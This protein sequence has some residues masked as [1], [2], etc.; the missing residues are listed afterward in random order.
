MNH[1]AWVIWTALQVT[2]P[3]GLLLRHGHG[4][5]MPG[6]VGHGVLEVVQ[7]QGGH[8]L[9]DAQPDQNA[10]YGDVDV[11]PGGSA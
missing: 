10:L 9:A 5:R 8:V 3:A 2:E 4:D 6:E 11:Q 7:E 1:P